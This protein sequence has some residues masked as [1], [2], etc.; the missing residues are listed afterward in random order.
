MTTQTTTDWTA[1]GIVASM[2]APDTALVETISVNG[3][4]Q[5]VA[6]VDGVPMPYETFSMLMLYR[7]A[8]KSVGLIC[9]TQGAGA[10]LSSSGKLP[11]VHLARLNG[12]IQDHRR[13]PSKH[14]LTAISGLGAV[15]WEV[16]K[17][18]YDRAACSSD[19]KSA[20]AAFAAMMARIEESYES[21][22]LDPQI[23][24]VEA[25]DF[26]DDRIVA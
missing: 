11:P 3:K 9:T 15:A 19:P 26:N 25:F 24:S 18:L 5:S 21:S 10:T 7:M 6:F 17:A 14:H 20:H 2:M 16:V 12:L 13:L 4:I 23:I 8:P 1:R 22:L